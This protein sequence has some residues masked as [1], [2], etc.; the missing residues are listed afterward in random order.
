LVKTLSHNQGHSKKRLQFLPG[1]YSTGASESISEKAIDLIPLNHIRELP[2]NEQ[3]IFI[4]GE[5]P[6]RCKKL[7]YFNHPLF[8]GR[9]DH[10]PLER[11]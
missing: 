4:Q 7:I 2:K 9:Y 3:Y 11:R 6:I 8:I 1:N 10:N 5:K